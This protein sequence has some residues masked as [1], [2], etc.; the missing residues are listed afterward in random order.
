[1]ADV[2]G[3]Q[4]SSLSMARVEQIVPVTLGERSYDIVLHPGLLATL[5]ER[6]SA[7]T[8]SPKIGVVTDSH[9]A[10]RYL[11]AALSS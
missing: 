3:Q 7:L 11:Q 6:L 5:G 4:R 8:T 2:L 9:V 10:R 1:M